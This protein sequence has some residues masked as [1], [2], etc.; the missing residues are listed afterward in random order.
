M[1]L[2]YPVISFVNKVHIHSRSNFFGN[3]NK[4]NKENQKLFSI[5][6]RVT[7]KTLPTYIWTIENDK[8]VPYENTL[9][10]IE[11][12]KKNNVKYQSKIYKKGRHGMALDD[13]SAIRHG[14]QEYKNKD[15]AKWVYLASDFMEEIIKNS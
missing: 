1:I 15:I 11:A 6:N 14:I 2:C 10:M 13:D 4:N 8:T 9:Y 12:L 5:E 3:K 7:S